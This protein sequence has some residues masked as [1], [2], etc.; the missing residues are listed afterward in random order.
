MQSKIFQAN[1]VKQKKL[2][3]REQ[4]Q[5]VKAQV[6]YEAREKSRQIHQQK[7]FGKQR[8]NEHLMKRVHDARTEVRKDADN[9]KS[10]IRNFEQEAYELERREAELL[11][12]LQQT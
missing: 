4:L 12:K 1:E 2:R 3:D 10:K 8:Q 11:A 6:D 7:Q 5:Q 9:L